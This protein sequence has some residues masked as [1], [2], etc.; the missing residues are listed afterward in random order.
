MAIIYSNAVGKA[1]GSMGTITYTTRAGK[2]LGKDRI[3]LT[4]NPKTFAQMRRRVQWANIVNIWHSFNGLLHPSFQ[5]RT[6]LISDFNRFVGVN[7]G[8]V[9][10]YL[11]QGEAS[12][13]G[14]VVAPYQMSWG[15]LPPISVSANGVAG[16]VGTDISLGI[17]TVNNSTTLKQFSRAI[18]E[19]NQHFQNGDQITAFVLLQTVNTV[20]GVPYTEVR[21]FEVTLDTED[22]ETLVADLDPELYVFANQGE[23]DKLGMNQSVNGGVV[24]IHSRLA[25]DNTTLVSSQRLVVS[26]TLLATYQSGAKLSAAVKSYGGDTASAYLTPNVDEAPVEA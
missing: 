5:D 11:T 10:I 22:N 24:Y 3:R 2:T 26:N 8:R 6:A 18:I 25:G 12:Q 16:E 9:P 7:I 1:K 20:T 17:L 4:T 21:A 23:T 19:S 15:T 14:A 13:G